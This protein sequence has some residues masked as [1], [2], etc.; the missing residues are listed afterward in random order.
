VAELD[1][2]LFHRALVEVAA[3]DDFKAMLRR[4][5]AM[6]GGVVGGIGEL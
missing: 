1:D 4:D 2:L 3:L 6:S 5:C